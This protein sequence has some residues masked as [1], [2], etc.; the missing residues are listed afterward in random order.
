[1]LDLSTFQRGGVYVA[2]RWLPNALLGALR[3][4]MRQLE[5]Q[6]A[7]APSGLTPRGAGSD[8]T[9]GESDRQVCPFTREIGGDDKARVL[10]PVLVR[11]VLLLLL[12]LL[13]IRRLIVAARCGLA[14]AARAQTH[15]VEH[16]GSDGG[17]RGEPEE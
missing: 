17:N 9:F 7:F 16:G 12:L 13:V 11:I 3:D 6:G 5:A 1:M 15:G 8:F 2:E 4:D 10:A 14:Q